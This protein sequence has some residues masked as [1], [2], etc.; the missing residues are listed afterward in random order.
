MTSKPGHA[1]SFLAAAEESN[2]ASISSLQLEMTPKLASACF[3]ITRL[4]EQKIDTLVDFAEL[5]ARREEIK[6]GINDMARVT[7]GKEAMH[8]RGINIGVI[9]V[10]VAFYISDSKF[11]R[12]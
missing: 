4:T 8:P 1:Q 2:S 12:S 9:S 5:A 11:N 10:D 3:A 6:L 7:L